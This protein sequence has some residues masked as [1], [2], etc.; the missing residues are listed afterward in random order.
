[1]GTNRRVGGLMEEW[2]GGNVSAM[3]PELHGMLVARCWVGV[4]GERGL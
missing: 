2:V 1:M 3:V 4:G